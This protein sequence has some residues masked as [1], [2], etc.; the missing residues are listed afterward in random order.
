M[1]KTASSSIPIRRRTVNTCSTARPGLLWQALALPLRTLRHAA[2]VRRPGARGPLAWRPR[3][4]LREAL[5]WLL[6]LLLALPHVPVVL[7]QVQLF[8]NR[9]LPSLFNPQPIAPLFTSPVLHWGPDIARWAA[10]YD[11]DP[12]LL[13]TVMQIESCGHPTVTSRA[14][15]QGLF[16]VMPFHFASGE[17]YLDPETNAMRGARFLK[18]C[19]GYASGDIGLTLACYNGGPSVV[20]RAF[21]SWAHE[22]QRYYNWGLG[23]YNDAAAGANHSPTLDAWLAAGGMHL[24][25][26][27][28]STLGLP[29]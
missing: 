13:A 5:P 17:D 19:T 27:A 25:S 7:G 20:R 15:A 4:Y 1:R 12:N 2:A 22:T 9:T 11:V 26:R 24:C 6:V 14:G 23:I 10:E 21:S 28:A 3:R 29:H 18:E 8:F 16:Q